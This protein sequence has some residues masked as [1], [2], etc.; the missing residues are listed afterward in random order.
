MSLETIYYITQ[1]VAVAAILISLVAIYFQQRQVHS[2]A[3]AE[4]EREVLA[5]WETAYDVIT[6][7][8]DALNSVKICLQ[9]YEGA[10]S[11]Q[12]AWF[13]YL[14]HIIINITERNVFLQRDKLARDVGLHDVK[15]VIRP[16]LAA[17]GGEQFW[18]RA[19]LAY[20]I[21][22]RQVL[23]S[24]LLEPYDGP[25]IWELFPFYAPETNE[26]SESK[27]EDKKQ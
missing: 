16:F 11:I 22:V 6:R 14:M 12:Q 23:D 5:K 20:G 21:D 26:A 1:I 25:M 2:L 24:A 3:R 19:R 27:L 17:P 9:D 8:P 10:A 18:Q 13:G 15:A 4:H 7:D